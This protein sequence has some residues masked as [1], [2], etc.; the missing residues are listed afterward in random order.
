MNFLFKVFKWQKKIE[1]IIV[2]QK[3]LRIRNQRVCFDIK[4]ILKKIITIFQP[5]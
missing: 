5:K 1:K 3:Y 2:S 4:H